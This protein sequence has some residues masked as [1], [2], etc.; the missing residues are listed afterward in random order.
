VAA[1]AE[2][3]DDT[4]T[5]LEAAAA[6]AFKPAAIVKPGPGDTAAAIQTRIDAGG[7]VPL[8]AGEHIVTGL[9]IKTGATLRG[10]GHGA[11]RIKLADGAN[12]D[13]LRR[14]RR[15]LQLGGWRVP[16]R[17]PHGGS[18]GRNWYS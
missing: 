17:L 1:A 11:T 10:E 3:I 16:L 6:A 2:D 4:T 8:G 15:H 14:Q 7:I 13:E 12:A 5:D 18:G 9:Q